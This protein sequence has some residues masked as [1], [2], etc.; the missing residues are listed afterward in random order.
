M[1][2][3]PGCRL[4]PGKARRTRSLSPSLSR[5]RWWDTILSSKRCDSAIYLQRLHRPPA[6]L[7]ESARCGAGC[8]DGGMRQGTSMWPRCGQRLR[9]RGSA[10]KTR[11]S[12]CGTRGS[13]RRQKRRRV[14]AQWFGRTGVRPCRRFTA[15]LAGHDPRA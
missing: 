14:S 9:A 6:A 1:R 12:M 2:R 3:W 4:L 11:S 10:K 8:E 13:L 5:Q 15:P 7:H